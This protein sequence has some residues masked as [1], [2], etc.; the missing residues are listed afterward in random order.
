MMHEVTAAL[1]R[2]HPE[3]LLTQQALTRRLRAIRNADWQPLYV[4]DHI[5]HLAH[6]MD[7]RIV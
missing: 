4:I 1:Y 5:S 7:H 6:L 2:S 3:L